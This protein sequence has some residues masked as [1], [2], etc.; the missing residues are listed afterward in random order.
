MNP[1][2]SLKKNQ[3]VSRWV[4]RTPVTPMEIIV[5]GYQANENPF[6][7]YRGFGCVSANNSSRL[8][9]DYKAEHPGAY[10]EIMRLLFEKNYGAGLSHIK[11][12]LGADINSSSGTEPC[13]KRTS[14]EKTDVT[15]GAGFQFAADAKKINPDITIDMLR[16]GQPGWVTRAFAISQETGLEARYRWY[17]D[18]IEAAYEV[19]GLK[20]D[21]ISVDQ[22]ETNIPDESWI[23]YFRYRLDNEKNQLYDYSKIRFIA[24]DEVGSIQIADQMVNNVSLRNA[25]SVIG[26]HYTTTGNAYTGLLNE[27][28]GTEI[29]CSEG[30]APCNVPELTVQEDN[31]GLIGTS[32]AIDIANRIINSYY[33]GKMVMYEFQ[34]AVAAYYDGAF[35]HPKQLIRA[36]EPWSGN[37]VLD[38]GFWLAMHFSRFAQPKWMFVNGACYGD[39]EE[40]NHSISNTHNN[41]MTLTSQDRQNF[42]MFFTNEDDKPRYYSVVVKN[43]SFQPSKLSVVVTRG[44]KDNQ[45]YDA[46]WFQKERRELHVVRGKEEP[47]F[48]IKVPPRSIMTV[49]TL[50]TSW[51]NG[52]NTFPE[53]QP[54]K[55]HRLTLPYTD[56]F[57]YTPDACT[58]RGST[59]R[60]MTDQGGAFE[61]TTDE[62]GGSVVVQQITPS[63][64]PTN[65]N[66]RGTP[67]PITCFGD[68]RWHHYI[69]SAEVRLSSR[70]KS[71]YAGIGIRY[72]S[73]STCKYS[74][75]CG[76]TGQLYGDRS[77]KLMD[78]EQVAAEGTLPDLDVTDW[79]E[80]KLM[81]IGASV[82]FFI[83]GIFLTKY[84]PN[85]IVNSGRV[86]L[87]S[88]YARNMFRNIQINPSEIGLPYVRRIDCLG[89]GIGY[90]ETWVAHTDESYTFYNRTSMEAKPGSVFSCDFDG[91]GIAILGTAKNAE[92]TILVDG[93][94]FFDKHFVQNCLPRQ[95][96][97]LIDSLALGRHNLRFELVS[98]EFLLDALEIPESLPNVPDTLRFTEQQRA[99][100]AKFCQASP[101][102][103][104]NHHTG[105]DLMDAEAILYHMEHPFEV[106][107]VK[108]DP[109]IQV[110]EIVPEQPEQ[111]EEKTEIPPVTTIEDGSE[112]TATETKEPSEST[113]NEKLAETPEPKQEKI[114]EP[115][116]ESVES[117]T[118][119]DDFLDADSLLDQAEHLNDPSTPSDTFLV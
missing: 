81:I 51:V 74:S 19:Y 59:P 29:W 115:P 18:T 1:F 66:G 63:I 53:I 12:E 80:L 105:D 86:S 28:Y 84:T 61:V 38:I 89:D 87:C 60:Y 90:D 75:L 107:P 37:Y 77:W 99:E 64:L 76:Y 42:S 9:L 71:N 88:A 102:P 113:E 5:D 101:A 72:N 35:Y 32:A 36:W 67:N 85:T 62:T 31:S 6:A 106:P 24:S 26:L 55:P 45:P 111:P 34:P 70:E 7:S 83:S 3:V 110:E 69:M 47:T 109:K 112:S 20:F 2:R 15:R 93:H 39:G 46:N 27:S 117:D 10:E 17:K 43:M 97:V 79:Q 68:D 95:A 118:P 78:M 54:P 11:I 98:G 4:D 104:S 56:N 8:L 65:W 41:F 16:W 96:C 50:D 114:P 57:A 49:T 25:V 108:P 92:F 30:S 48:E 116:V 13:V 58:V 22:N 33:C 21:F 73:S 52:V 82:F 23:L 14:D 100:Y 40:K 44:P 103:K 91:A 94:T 119:E